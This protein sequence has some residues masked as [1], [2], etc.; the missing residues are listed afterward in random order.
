MTPLADT[1]LISI[2]IWFD[3]NCRICISLII[4]SRYSL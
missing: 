2:H 3:S 1:L 4:N